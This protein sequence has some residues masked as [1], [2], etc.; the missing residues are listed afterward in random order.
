MTTQAPKLPPGFLPLNLAEQ[1]SLPPPSKGRSQK[2]EV[3]LMSDHALVPLTRGLFAAIDL[4]DVQL[5]AGNAWQATSHGAINYARTRDSFYMHYVIS[6]QKWIDHADGDG[7]NNRRSNLRPA[8][9]SQNVVNRKP[10]PGASGFS[11]VDRRES[12]SFRAKISVEGRAITLGHFKTAEE[13]SAAYQRASLELH[14]E[15]AA[16]RIARSA[17]PV[18]VCM[19]LLCPVHGSCKRYHDVNGSDPE[20]S[21]QNSCGTGNERPM[22]VRLSE[23][24]S[25]R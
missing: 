12:G 6:R 10:R 15:F 22:F 25:R 13:A 19:G 2:R 8:T 17:E 23:R 11:G 3:I 1:V 9:P 7:L 18:T 20:G 21:R 4:A 14:G 5:V 16:T 24:A